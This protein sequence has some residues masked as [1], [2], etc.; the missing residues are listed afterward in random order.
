MPTYVY[1]CRDCGDT[2]QSFSMKEKPDSIPCPGC[3]AT[4]PSVFTPPHLGAGSTTAHKLM[5]ATKKTAE[6]P[7]V[8]SHIPGSTRAPRPVSRDP[9]HAKLPRP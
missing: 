9:R 8:V 3:S 6:A 7:A 4:A 5:D 1:R 2:Q